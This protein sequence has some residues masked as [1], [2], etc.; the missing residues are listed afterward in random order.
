MIYIYHILTFL[1]LPIY[2]V[3]LIIRVL[4]GKEEIKSISQRFGSTNKNRPQGT[5]IWIHAASVGESMVALTLIEGINSILPTVNILVTSGT[6]SSASILKKKLPTNAIHQFLPLDNI[7]FV[8]K[9][10]KSWQPILG[11]FIESELWPCLVIESS[12]VCKLLLFNARI[13]DRSFKSWGKFKS[14][15]QLIMSHFSEIIV[16]SSVDLEKFRQLGISKAINLGNIKF[17]NK[18]LEVDQSKF[19]ELLN[20]LIDKT[21]IVIASTHVEDEQVF[22]KIIK[23]IKALYP[24][25]YFILIPR[26]PERRNEINKMSQQLN[27]T[28]NFRSEL[29]LPVLSDDLYIVDKLGEVGL[30]YNLAYISFVGG[31]FKRGGHNVLEPAHFGNLIVFG[32]DMSNFRTIASEMIESN[33]A[34]QI[35]NEDHLLETLKHLLTGN[36]NVKVYQTNA[37]EFIKKNQQILPNYLAI[38]SQF[39]KK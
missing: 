15:F 34:I 13:S 24:A 17:S 30:F 31:S 16:Q 39:I 6:I 5:L 1:L 29:D 37:L 32:P 22:F 18:K 26:H 2:L 11:I 27:L 10:L 35:R 3:L 38:I 8:R 33:A 9:F 7:I 36:E 12:K 28:V 4:K 14:F 21:I 25:C 20:H 19:S 23:P